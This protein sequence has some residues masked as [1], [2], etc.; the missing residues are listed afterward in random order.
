MLGF[1]RGGLA[2]HESEGGQQLSGGPLAKFGP[3]SGDAERCRCVAGCRDGP[4]GRMRREA[5]PIS[6][7]EATR[8]PGQSTSRGK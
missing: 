1:S 7:T 6:T 8:T 2:V 3:V 5:E 4:C